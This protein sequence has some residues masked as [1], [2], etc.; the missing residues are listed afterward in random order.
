MSLIT[1]REQKPIR[2]VKKTSYHHRQ[3]STVHKHW[4]CLSSQSG[5][6]NLSGKQRKHHIIIIN[7]QQYKNAG[8]ASHHNPGTDAYQESKENTISSLTINSTETL[9]ISLITVWEQIPIRKVKKTPH[10]HRQQ[11]T[12]QKR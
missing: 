1:V 4:T 11:S 7:N 8:H 9:D 3:Q 12:V 5:S 10:H 6:S 2:R